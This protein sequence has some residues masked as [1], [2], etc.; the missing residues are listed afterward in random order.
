MV[1]WAPSVDGDAHA[2]RTETSLLLALD[3]GRVRLERGRGR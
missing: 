1:A 2:G 3:P